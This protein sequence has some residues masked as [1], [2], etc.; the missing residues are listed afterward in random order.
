[1]YCGAKPIFVDI[2]KR[3]YN[4]EPKAIIEKINKNTKAIIPVHIFGQSA[5]MDEIIE[6]A[7]DHNIPIIEDAAC[8]LGAKY[9]DKFVGTIGDIGCFSF[10]ARKGIT[11]GEG[12]MVITNNPTLAE[13][14]RRLSVFG[15]IPAKD[16]KGSD[17]LTFG[18]FPDLGYNYKMSDISAA[19]GV[20]QLKKL[21]KI[22]KKKIEL[23]KYFNSELN[24][25]E[26]ITAPYVEKDRNHI[27]QSYVT[28]LDKKINRNELIS[29]LRRL[30][31]Q[32]Q[33]G[34]YSSHIQPIYKSSDKCPVSFE[35]FNTA[36]A[37]P[38]FYELTMEEID[39]IVSKL[40]NVMEGIR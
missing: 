17:K 15:M 26:K 18:V 37:L 8:A 13:K 1:M 2:N 36:L 20:A 7:T 39:I 22:I 16:R 21:D 25:I 31:I 40:R 29:K 3:T 23:A 35:T 27:Y 9:K 12:G 5:D 6:T 28:I 19:V 10:H 34:T 30:G 4:I 24:K 38:M 11:T 14:I 32:T 33:I